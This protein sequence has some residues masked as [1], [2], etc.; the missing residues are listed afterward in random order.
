MTTKTKS[1]ASNLLR[2]FCAGLTLRL[3]VATLLPLWMDNTSVPYTDIDYHVFLDASYHDNPYDRATYRYTPW[4]AFLL[5]QL[6]YREISARYLFCLAD[7]LCGLWLGPLWLY[8]PLAINI[9]TRGSAESLQVLLP[10]LL[11]LHCAQQGHV[12]LAG[13]LHGFALH[14]KLY[15]LIYS[16]TY[17]VHWWRTRRPRDAILFVCATGVSFF[18]LTVAGV[19][20]FGPRA[21]QEGLLYHLQRSD[22]RHNYAMHW[23]SVYLGTNRI[24]PPTL[25]QAVLLFVTSFARKPLP[26]ILFVQTFLFVA[27]NSVVTA[28]YFVWYLCLWPLVPQL[29]CG[30]RAL[31]LL[32]LSMG[33]WL[34]SGYLLEMQGLPVHLYVWMASILFLGAHLNCLVRCL[35]GPVTRKN[36]W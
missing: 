36:V 28:Q 13:L 32:L 19:Y 18:G 30:W 27:L 35:D 5:K 17:S 24:I 11:T 4:L 26:W 2:H 22:H 8:H 10:V 14:A 7:A 15:P 20:W 12:I 25:I 29:W 9:C 3:V 21:L 31:V 6:P 23:Y 1:N 34:G 33:L 16:L